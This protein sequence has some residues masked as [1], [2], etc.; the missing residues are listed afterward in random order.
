VFVY[1][2]RSVGMYQLGRIR[3]AIGQFIPRFSSHEPNMIPPCLGLCSLTKLVFIQ[4]L[5]GGVGG[6]GKERGGTCIL[7]I[8]MFLQ[9]ANHLSL[10]S[11]LS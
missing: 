10:V 7:E 4:P 11:S 9:L 5:D 2:C 1:M 6:F 8:V 3:T